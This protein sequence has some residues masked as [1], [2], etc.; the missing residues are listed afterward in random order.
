MITTLRQALSRAASALA[1]A[2]VAAILTGLLS[3]LRGA[4]SGA[5]WAL[6]WRLAGL[7]VVVAAVVG[8]G[9][10]LFMA[11]VTP[12]RREAL[13][14]AVLRHPRAVGATALFV[15]PA[16]V[17]WMGLGSLAGRH[18]LTAYHHVGLA[19]FAQSAALVTLTLVVVATTGLLI[20][21]TRRF[22]P[23][24]PRRARFALGVPLGVGLVL[25]AAMVAHG[26]YW[27]DVDGHSPLK[28][29]F[30]GGFGV[31]K[32]PELDL[33]P[34]AQLAG[35]VL[36]GLCLALLFLRRAGV[37]LLL[38][39]A[40][41]AGLLWADATAF[42]RHDAAATID[43]RPSLARVVLRALR[44]RTD[45]D[46]DGFAARFGGGDCNDAD[47]A[48]NPDAIDVP[49][50]GRDED[51]SGSDAQRSR[52]APA[53]PPAP[54]P[55][56]DAGAT[57]DA[58]APPST[59]PADAATAPVDAA[60]AAPAAGPL[61]LVLITV[62]TL[63]YD[64]HYA[65]NPNP[66]S[67]NLDRLA[68]ASVVFDRGYA[69]SSYTGRAIAPMMTGRY[70]TECARDSEHFTRY[71]PANVMLAERLREAGYRT[72]GAASH[73]YFERSFGLTQGIEDW[74]TSAR[75][76]GE[77]QETSAADARVADR[78][79]AMMQDPARTQGRFLMW[80]HFFDPHKQYVDHPDLPLFGRNERA[81]YDR[82]VMSTDREIGRLLAAL[83]ALPN[84]VAGRT[85]VVVTADHGEA[86]NEHGMSWH[87]VEL[88]EELVR[89][90]WIMRVPGLAPRRITTPRS[91][92]DLAPTL[93]ELLGL[94]GPAQDAP[95]AFSGVSLAGE[96]RGAEAT[97][98]PVYIELPEGPFNS[99]RRSVIDGGW[100]LTERGARRFELYNL[101]DDP[102]ERTNLAATQPEALARMRQVMDQVRAGL[103]LVA[104]PPVN[105]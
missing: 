46:H 51:C 68:A 86:F 6:G 60:S 26:V 57:V 53:A 48:I 69:I 77:G 22:F 73:F 71:L 16:T 14:A 97:P 84:G 72:F 41:S 76:H 96:L 78:A 18:F 63:R 102:G 25:A 90:P 99:L 103:H 93:V 17:L 8:P 65:G 85:V 75:P 15:P 92:V 11:W 42:E 80:V 67:P 31:L 81:R 36:G 89:V 88:W 23:A 19:S 32:K 30:L 95:D 47:P 56:A 55:I 5:V 34:V 50:N 33:T 2:L 101:G 59:A 12:S 98:R 20:A 64:L 1:G 94:Q 24:E 39:L 70:P 91:Q 28:A 82:E 45:R 79:I 38:S 74:D 13:S 54:R 27:G 83:D 105:H 7:L 52:R 100:K 29:L 44:R 4:P 9:L 62:D 58:A 66:I 61:N 21:V 87:G 3:G 104:A 43:A 10:A 49:E 37:I 35:V 40:L